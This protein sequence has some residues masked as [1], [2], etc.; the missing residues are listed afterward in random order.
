MS[1]VLLLLVIVK[2]MKLPIKHLLK[3]LHSITFAT[4]NTALVKFLCFFYTFL[5]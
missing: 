2:Y 4:V 3:N 5:L 1:K